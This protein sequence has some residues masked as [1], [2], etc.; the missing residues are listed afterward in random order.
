MKTFTIATVA[1]VTGLTI[2][3]S[4]I[5][6][7]TVVRSGGETAIQLANS[8][9]PNPCGEAGIQG[10]QYTDGGNI[11]RVRCVGGAAGTDGMSGGL[12]AGVAA[13]VAIITIAALAS[14]GDSSTGTTSTSTTGTN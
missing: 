4:G 1:L 10:A 3:T 14:D 7:Q 8:I 11:L 9:T 5:A 12:A 6:Q 13:G 2:S